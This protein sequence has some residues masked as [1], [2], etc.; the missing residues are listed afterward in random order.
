MG[1]ED[2]ERSI[3]DRLERRDY[4]GGRDGRLVSPLGA[5]GALRGAARVPLPRRSSPARPPRRPPDGV[6]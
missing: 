4:A 2:L 6:E 5:A 1:S 3:R